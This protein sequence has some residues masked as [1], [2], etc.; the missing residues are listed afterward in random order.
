MN[1]GYYNFAKFDDFFSHSP[2]DG[3]KFVSANMR[4]R[5]CQNSLVSPEFSLR[6]GVGMRAIGESSQSELWSCQFPL[7]LIMTFAPVMYLRRNAVSSV[8]IL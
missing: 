6:I 5:V 7:S 1:F 8:F 4:M 2:D 3:R